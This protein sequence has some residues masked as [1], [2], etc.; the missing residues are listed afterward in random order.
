MDTASILVVE[1]EAVIAI[2]LQE[3]LI[4][5]GY[6]VQG[7]IATGEEALIAAAELRPDLVM[8]DIR[9]AGRLDGIAVAEQLRATMD[10]PI[11]FL[12]AHAD[13]ETV[14]RAGGTEPYAYLLKPFDESELAITLQLVLQRSG[15]DQAQ[16][17][18]M[19]ALTADRDS[20][21]AALASVSAALRRAEQSRDLFLSSLSHE[22]RTPLNTILGAAELLD[23]EVLGALTIQQRGAVQRITRGGSRLL[24]L[25]ARLLDYVALASGQAAARIETV[26]LEQVCRQCL[27]VAQAAADAKGLQLLSSIPSGIT[28]SADPAQLIQMLTI[29]LE[30][31]V[32]FTPG[33]GR[34]GLEVTLDEL[35]ASVQLTIWDTGIGI[36][37]EQRDRL[38]QPFS[39]ID[40]RLA[41]SYD[42]VGLGLALA[43]RVVQLHHGTISVES[44]P[45]HG[46]RFIIR[47]PRNL[48]GILG[49]L[50]RV[51]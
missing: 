29:V 44:T 18:V 42:G 19:S 3:T 28:I 6:T 32:K 30:N 9:L 14:A 34:I 8:L 16:A 25:V 17:H 22:L 2:D 12:T 15:R 49:H 33:G 7:P 50:S 35:N 23:D 1:D 51:D 36:A 37:E 46:S 43:H 47:I 5:L 27:A 24:A 26:A 13:A 20:S 40:A 21:R 10:V 41:R 39:Q 48:N 31:A 38:F 11:I 45:G 4:G